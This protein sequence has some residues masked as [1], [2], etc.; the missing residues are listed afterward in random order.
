MV[1]AYT[2]PLQIRI[3]DWRLDIVIDEEMAGKEMVAKWWREKEMARKR[4]GGKKTTKKLVS[5]EVKTEEPKEGKDDSRERHVCAC[6]HNSERKPCGRKCRS[7][8]P[9]GWVSWVLLPSESFS[10]LFFPAFKVRSS[11]AITYSPSGLPWLAFVDEI[12]LNVINVK[13]RGDTESRE[14]DRE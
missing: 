4:D 7:W 11:N 10:F 14:R 6:E 5:E 13:R 8:L 1:T 12:L 3:S 2:K 9:G